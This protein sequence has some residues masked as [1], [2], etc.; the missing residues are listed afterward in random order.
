VEKKGLRS[1]GLFH[2]SQMKVRCFSGNAYGTVSIF[3]KYHYF[4]WKNRGVVVRGG[5]SPD[6]PVFLPN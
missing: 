6:V 3:R 2:F 4:P 1:A 5:F